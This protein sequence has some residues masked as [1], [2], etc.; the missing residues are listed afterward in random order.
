M[1]TNSITVRP[2]PSVAEHLRKSFRAK[3]GNKIESFPIAGYDGLFVTFRA[4][5][6]YAEVRNATVEVVKRR[7]VPEAERE[8]EIGIETLKLS[9]I[10]S[11]AI[12]DGQ[13][14]DI[15][16]PLGVDLYDYIFAA[17][18]DADDA[19]EHRPQTDNEAIILLFDNTM[20]LMLL[21]SRLD[22]WF[23]GEAISTDEEL[24][25]E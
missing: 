8:I 18:P 21:A 16:L 10:G 1:D 12:I 11:Y 24:L 6:D 25:G 23:K 5:D 22:R 15:G 17:D 19:P 4:L 7:G 20:A 9:S 3:Q 14:I 2:T 13:K